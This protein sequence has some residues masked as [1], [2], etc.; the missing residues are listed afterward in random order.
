M[1]PAMGSLRTLKLEFGR[2]DHSDAIDTDICNALARCRTLRT[3]SVGYNRGHF[4]RKSRLHACER[5]FKLAGE[6]L[7]SLTLWLYALQAELLHKVS[8]AIGLQCPVLNSLKLRLYS[9]D[10]RKL[11]S[12]K[13]LFTNTLKKLTLG[14]DHASGLTAFLDNLVDPAFLPSLESAPALLWVESLSGSIPLA[15]VEKALRALH[16]RG[17][18][19]DLASMS[20]GL[21]SICERQSEGH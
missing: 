5:F 10:D 18:I 19:K 3:L 15:T 4:D 12:F 11:E 7:H 17:T 20:A 21:Y 2:E 13:P 14:V 6:H 16:Q 1:A 8:T 9:C